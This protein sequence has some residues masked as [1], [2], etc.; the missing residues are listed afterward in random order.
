MTQATAP[1]QHAQQTY[2]AR[3]YQ[4]ASGEWAWSI[5]LDGEFVARGAGFES[6]EAAEDYLYE[7]LQRPYSLILEHDPD[8]GVIYGPVLYGEVVRGGQV[9]IRA[10]G[11]PGQSMFAPVLESL[12]S[13]TCPQCYG[14]GYLRL[15][16]L[17]G[18]IDC[19]NCYGH[20]EVFQLDDVEVSE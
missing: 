15:Y 18:H 7:H 6:G 12:P 4:A 19:P 11:C 3:V 8:A 9:I 16:G 2:R 20:G 17:D 14:S 10:M 1:Q 13:Q 5:A